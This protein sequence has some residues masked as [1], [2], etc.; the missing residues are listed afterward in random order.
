M[1][2]EPKR[3]DPTKTSFTSHLPRNVKIDNIADLAGE[4]DR[5][6][7]WFTLPREATS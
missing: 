7:Q 5:F 6:S 4:G 3:T 1:A 2:V